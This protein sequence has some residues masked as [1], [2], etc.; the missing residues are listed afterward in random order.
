[1][2]LNEVIAEKL[3]ERMLQP[4]HTRD[5]KS[6]AALLNMPIWVER[7]YARALSII[8]VE[9]H[10]SDADQLRTLGYYMTHQLTSN[11]SLA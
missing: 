1:M 5:F 7:C 9:G 2:P 11:Q 4:A 3:I 10:T 8:Q 6:E